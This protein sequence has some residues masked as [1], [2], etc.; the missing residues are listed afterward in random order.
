MFSKT[1]NNYKLIFYLN[2]NLTMPENPGNTKKAFVDM[3]INE[4]MEY[5]F[6]EYKP[7]DNFIKAPK[8]N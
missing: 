8:N 6:G 2:Y 1:K 7:I 5:I 3:N 4:Q